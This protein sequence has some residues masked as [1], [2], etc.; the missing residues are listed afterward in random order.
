LSVSIVKKGDSD[1]PAL[2]DTQKPR[3]LG[4]KRA[5]KLKKLFGIV[6]DKKDSSLETALLR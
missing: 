3:R 2:T 6:L 1:I 4:P 5:T